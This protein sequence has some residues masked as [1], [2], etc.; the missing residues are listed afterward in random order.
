MFTGALVHLAIIVCVLFHMFNLGTIESENKWCYFTWP[1]MHLYYAFVNYV[2]IWF[3]C[4]NAYEIK[5]KHGQNI[6]SVSNK[7][8][9]LFFIFSFT[10]FPLK[11]LSSRQC[12]VWTLSWHSVNLEFAHVFLVTLLTFVYMNWFEKKYIGF[13]IY[14]KSTNFN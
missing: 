1:L 8:L 12:K 10:F 11:W 4:Y 14:Y 3:F 13:R 5:K 9:K 7:F 2:F 6:I